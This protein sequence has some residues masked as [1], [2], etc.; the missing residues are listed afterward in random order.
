M[1][2]HRRGEGHAGIDS[3]IEKA[4]RQ[5]PGYRLRLVSKIVTGFVDA[6]RRTTDACVGN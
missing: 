5:F 2:A 4:Q 3:M 6:A 1:D